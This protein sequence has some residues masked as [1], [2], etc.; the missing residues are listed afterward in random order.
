[1][2]RIKIGVSAATALLAASV[3][4]AGIDVH[5]YVPKAPPVAIVETRPAAPGAEFVWIPGYH[6]WEAGAYVWEPGRWE[7][8][9]HAHGR[10][11]AGQWRHH[12]HNGWYWT[13]GRWR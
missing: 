3:S 1:M 13:E 11:V 12:P 6:R 4:F 10:W 2:S 7:R 8:P 9:P 5:I